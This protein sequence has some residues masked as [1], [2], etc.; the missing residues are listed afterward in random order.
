M[1][2][3]FYNIRDAY[4]KAGIKDP[5]EETL[6]LLDVVSNGAVGKMD[7]AFPL[8]TGAEIED[9]IAVRLKGIPLEYALGYGTFMGM[10][11][12]CSP[13]ALIPRQ[14]TELLAKTA[15][16][17]FGQM[18]NSG[19]PSVIVDMG[20]G[21]GNIAVS[22]AANTKN[23]HVLACDVS[24]EAI[25]LAR[26]N[27]NRH[28]LQSRVSLF[29]G[30]LFA[31]LAAAGYQGGTNM[32][33]CNPPYIPTA[34]L[35]KMGRG[36]IDH[37]PVAA[38]DAGAYGIDIF[39]GLIS[40]APIFLKPKGVL[41]FEIGKGQEKFVTRLLQK[42]GSYRDICHHA[43][44]SGTIRVISATSTP[45]PKDQPGKAREQNAPTLKIVKE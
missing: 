3:G 36:I 26:A 27:V 19:A 16:H 32:V 1:F 38:F 9:F 21:S 43:D 40:Q 39:R 20:T 35:A 12:L 44:K 45:Q 41:V 18:D 15:I 13:A 33:V 2:E 24:P 7:E 11:L 25:E 30:D 28:N 22:I 4:E 34:S 10:Q 29:T 42:S 8:K 6:K 31:P 23:P 14:E 37:E 5:L 17:L